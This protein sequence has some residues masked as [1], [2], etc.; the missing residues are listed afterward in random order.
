M[1]IPTYCSWI[2]RKILELRPLA[3]QSLKYIVGNCMSFSLRF[4]PWWQ[5][6][7]LETSDLD[8]IIRQSGLP[9]D[10]RVSVISNGSWSLPAPQPHIHHPSV[11]FLYWLENFDNPTFDTNQSDSISWNGTTVSRIK[12][13]HIWD[14]IRFKLPQIAW[15]KWVC[16]N[17]R[18]L[19]MLT[20]NGWFV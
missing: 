6:S 18:L 10:A 8:A 16:T 13:V 2:W 9:P 11:I 17:F 3:M 7:C 20:M 12:V 4:D 15:Y 19:V 5:G 1:S 14:A